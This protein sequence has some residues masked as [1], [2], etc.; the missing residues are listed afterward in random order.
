LQRT[1]GAGLL[2]RGGS[3]ALNMSVERLEEL[4]ERALEVAGGEE[5]LVAE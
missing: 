5:L 2:L 3:H 1:A 4:S